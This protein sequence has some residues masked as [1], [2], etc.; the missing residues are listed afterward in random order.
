MNAMRTVVLALIFATSAP[1]HAVHLP[2]PT[3]AE[4]AL[5][6]S[7]AV[8][9]AR[10]ELTA[11]SLQSEGLRQGREEWT[12]G[13]DLAQR[14]SSGGTTTREGE[15]AV[16]LMRAVRLPGRAAA[17]GALAGARLA[18]AEASLG[19][20]V[21]ESGRH[22]LALW[23]EWLAEA[24]QASLWQGQVALAERQLATV[25]ARIRLGEAPS[26][27]RAHA[28]AALA[29]VRLAQRQSAVRTQ[30]AYARLLADYPD[31]PVEF[32]GELP[33]AQP[34]E[35]SADAH[36]DA[37]LAH[38]HELARARR[39]ADVLQAEA[40]QLAQRR[41][42]DPS[43]G[44][45]YRNEAGGDERV[46]GVNVGLTLP[47]AARRFDALAATQLGATAHAAA[48]RLEQRLRVEARA[49]YE[50]VLEQAAAWQQAEQA[51]QA[52]GEAARLAARAYSL[53]EASLDRVLP[54]Q[55]LALEARVQAQQVRVAA[56]AADAR[57]K[58]DAHR[59]WALDVVAGEGAHP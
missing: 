57:L 38:N 9:Q 56:L 11:Q 36:V 2:D 4:A 18:H 34:P 14:R 35:G 15:W 54:A 39:H 42:I 21:H 52:L 59:L 33:V 3:A 6:A 47:G 5:R 29:Q 23:F 43:V 1:A 12:V 58:L 13:A 10:G 53:G 17:D 32:D 31:L 22:L 45:F 41:S 46:L 40:R 49:D 20:A 19:E 24:S 37:V 55:R 28:E 7:V 50:T 25:E 16:S 48:L 26:A 51:A 27:E 8:M 30:Q 44:V